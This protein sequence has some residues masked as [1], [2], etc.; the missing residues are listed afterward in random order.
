MEAKS[1]AVIGSGTD[2]AISVL[3][4]EKQKL[5]ERKLNLD[6]SV[7]LAVKAISRAGER[8]N[9]TADI[10][11]ADPNIIKITLEGCEDIEP[12]TVSRSIKNL[13]EQEA[14]RG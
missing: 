12:E 1:Y 8:D 5:A 14:H 4:E 2:G 11:V 10:R 6:E 13:L 9:G 3:R 7:N